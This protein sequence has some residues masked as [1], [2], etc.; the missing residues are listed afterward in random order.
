MQALA[1]SS[2]WT[3][4]KKR[5]FLIRINFTDKPEEP[6][7]LSSVES[8]MAQ[9][10]EMIRLMSYGKTWVETKASAN[11][12]TMPQTLAYYASTPD[13]VASEPILMRDARN[14]F[15]QQKS[16][17][18]AAINIGPVSS[19]TN[20]DGGG[21]GDYD[22]VGMYRSTMD[23]EGAGGGAGGS[24][25]LV[26]G[27]WANTVGLFTHEWGHNYG[28]HHSSLWKT[29]DGSV[30]GAGAI[31]EYGDPFDNMGTGRLPEAH[32]RP[33]GKAALGWIAPDQWTDVSSGSGT[34]RIYR[35]DDPA[36]SS[37]PRAIR[38]A[39]GGNAT[40]YGYYWIGHRGAFSDNP[41][42]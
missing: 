9:S 26:K 39:K 15:R 17:A 22:I 24:F 32:F 37:G 31:D 21:L 30:E 34:F 6:V 12:Y 35:I 29:T 33:E 38:V 11:V 28:L 5:L 4:S 8:V 10:S 41:R 36:V 20:G 13:I 3:E 42:I 1:E 16:G 7:S 27:A 25:L 23:G 2:S 14:T 18:D 40:E 19:S